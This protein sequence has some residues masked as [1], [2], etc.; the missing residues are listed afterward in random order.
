MTVA[1]NIRHILLPPVLPEVKPFYYGLSAEAGVV[2]TKSV[3]VVP[4]LYHAFYSFHVFERLDLLWDTFVT[5]YEVYCAFVKSNEKYTPFN[6]NNFDFMFVIGLVIMPYIVIL[7]V[8]ILTH[9]ALMII[10]AVISPASRLFLIFPYLPVYFGGSP[11]SISKTW[12]N[13]RLPF[14]RHI[15]FYKYLTLYSR[16]FNF[17]V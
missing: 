8:I 14:S 15:K 17:N 11:T 13:R 9:F 4:Y 12:I 1:F 7:D 5:I 6:M 2:N 10:S 16:Y 3:N